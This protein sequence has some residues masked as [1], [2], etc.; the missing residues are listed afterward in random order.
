MVR[1][2]HLR[3]TT[4]AVLAVLSSAHE[5]HAQNERAFTRVWQIGSMDGDAAY[6]FALI[7]DIA[8]GHDGSIAPG[9]TSRWH[10]AVPRVPARG[11]HFEGSS[12]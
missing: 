3:L 2:T 8:F 4:L 11:F 1:S 9:A 7:G 5:A 10:A 6:V 12:G